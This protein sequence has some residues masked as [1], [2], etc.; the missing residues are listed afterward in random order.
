MSNILPFIAEENWIVNHWLTQEKFWVAF[1]ALIT[2]LTLVY[3]VT[4]NYRRNKKEKI[5][6]KFALFA[7]TF[8]NVNNIFSG[9][10]DVPFIYDAYKV[11]CRKYVGEIADSGILA[12]WQTLYLKLE[13]YERFVTRFYMNENVNRRYVTEFQLNVC[14]IFLTHFGLQMIEYSFDDLNSPEGNAY[15]ESKR[16]DA[17]R[18][19]DQNIIKFATIINMEI[20]RMLPTGKIARLLGSLDFSD[21]TWIL[22]T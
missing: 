1:S 11:L 14:N 10:V 17:I 7:E 9:G 3:T 8:T 18:V 6:L 15:I 2:M 4:W 21:G 22:P 20:E 13:H 16:D 12:R 5:N 19:K